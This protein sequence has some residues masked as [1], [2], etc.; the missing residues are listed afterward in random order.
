MGITLR[1]SAF[2]LIELL[3]VIAII[4]ILIGL[5]LPAVQKVREAAARMQSANNLKQIALATHGFHDAN[6]NLPTGYG[7]AKGSSNSSATPAQRGTF[8]YFLLPYIEQANVYNATANNSGTS[9]AVI[10]TFIA[11][12]DPSMTGD[13]RAANS[14]GVS[15][16]LCSYM[17]NGY[18]LTGDTNAMSYYLTG[19]S[20]N[21]NTADGSTTVYARIP[22]DV[23]DGTSNT[24]LLAERYA[25]NCL[26]STGVYGNRTWGDIAGPS[27]WTP[28]LIHTDMFEVK[29][30]LTN[31]SCYVP[32]SYS[33]SGCQVGLMDGSVRTAPNN[34]SSTTWWQLW[35]PRD[36]KVIGNW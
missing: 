15:A 4:A 8:F 20:S 5:L 13:R 14:A 7:F 3:V 27:R 6:G 35:L 1:R 16:G 17:A 30:P 29:P 25:N 22:A 9:T 19:T 36:G 32:Q 21:G 28:V 10:S 34:I 24:L 11:P 33:A 18:L 31:V 23:S 2:T 12:L 26:Y